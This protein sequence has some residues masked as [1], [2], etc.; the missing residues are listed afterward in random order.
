M[1]PKVI[2]KWESYYCGVPALTHRPKRLFWTNTGFRTGAIYQSMGNV[3]TS[4]YN[5]YINFFLKFEILFYSF[6]CEWKLYV[7]ILCKVIYYMVSTLSSQFNYLRYVLI[8]IY[9]WNHER[10]F[11]WINLKWKSILHAQTRTILIFQ[12][13]EIIFHLLS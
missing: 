6:F 13:A 10:I 1:L 5:T 12:N 9:F 2:F 8:F 7:I 11:F 4:E 3:V